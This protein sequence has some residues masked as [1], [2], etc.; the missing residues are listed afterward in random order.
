MISGIV[1]G[2]PVAGG[3]GGDPYWDDVTSLIHFDGANGGTTFTDQKPITW[4]RTAGAVTSTAQFKFGTASMSVSGG[5][6]TADDALSASGFGTGDFTIE[7]WFYATSTATRGVFDS[8]LG[9]SA[10]SIAL[11][12]DQGSTV[13]QI[14]FNGSVYSSSSTSITLNAWRHFAMVRSG[15]DL[16][17]YINGVATISVTGA[18]ANLSYTDMNYGAYFNGSFP[19]VGYIDECRITKGVARYTADFTPPSAPFPNS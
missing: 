19:W 12:W 9:S 10:A 14:Y 3:G 16:V 6:V 2:A 17:V 4:V 5:Y 8:V 11:G 18:T 13:W 7:G 1:A 15:S